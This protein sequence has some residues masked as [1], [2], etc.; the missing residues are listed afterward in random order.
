VPNLIGF[1]IRVSAFLRKEV[2]E[3]L[4][5]P[6]LVLTL[7]LGPFLILL[8]FGVGYRNEPRPLRAVFVMQPDSPFSQYLEEYVSSFGPLI[9]YEGTTDEILEAQEQ[10]RRGSA[11]VVVVLPENPVETIR[12]SEQAVFTLYHNEIDPFQAEYIAVFGRVYVDEVNRRVLASL[13]EQGQEE[14]VTLQERLQTARSSATAMRQA[15]E[16]GNTLA[17]LTERANLLRGVGAIALALGANTRLLSSVEQTFGAE[18][19]TANSVLEELAAIQSDLEAL[20]NI[21]SGRDNYSAEAQQV[22]EIEQ[23]LTTIDET[24]SEF[25]QIS[26]HVL[27]SPFF[28]ETE[29]IGQI[30]LRVSDYYVPAVIA[31]LIQHIAITFAALSIVRERNEGAMELF[32]VSPL[33]ALEALSGKFVS[34]FIFEALLAAIL[35]ALIVFGLKVPMLGSWFNYSIVLGVLLFTSLGVGFVISLLAQTTSQAV[36]YAMIILLA[37][38]FFSGFFLA[39][40]LLWQP[41]RIISWLLPVT[42][43]IQLLQN[44]MLRGTFN[45]L[46]LL[47]ALAGMGIA[48]F[49]LA[50][51]MLRRQM[52]LR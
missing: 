52:A 39:L 4:R 15:L 43:A 38:I 24:L 7:I 17:A 31:L 46:H 37:S 22:A 47:L 33:T 8:L 3:I 50:W 27:V 36:Q 9:H 29:S 5:Q 34:Y 11:D 40:P 25:R 1:F 51:L 26:P 13:T 21:E 14:S 48:F 28:S 49:L 32:R 44:I 10:L 12:N 20:E 23:E 30:L 6:R 19:G 18:D 41:V 42:Y 35:T 2:F 16:Q 45:Q